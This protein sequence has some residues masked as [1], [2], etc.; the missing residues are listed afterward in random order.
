LASKS[1]VLL[2]NDQEL[3]PL[4]KSRKIAVIG[5][6]ADSRRNMLGTWSVSGDYTKAVTVLEGIQSVVGDKATIVYAK[7]ANLSDDTSFAKKVNVFGLE[8]DMDKKN[9]DAL[10]KEAIQA[11]RQSDVV[12]AVVGEAADMTGEASSMADI[13]LQPSQKKL[14]EALKKTGKPIVMVLYNGRPM[15]LKWE[16]DNM[17]AILDVWFGG[18]EGGRAV[19]DV[20]FGDSNPQGRLTTSFPVQVGQIPVYHAMLN[21]GRPYHGESNSKYK[22]N[23]LDIPNEPLYPF[24]YGLTYSSVSYGEPAVSATIMKGGGSVMVSAQISNTGSTDAVETVQMY[25][26][27]VVGTIARPVKELKGFQQI[28][29]KPGES[30]TV[31]FT[32]DESLLKFYNGN[33]QY[34]AEPGKFEVM[35]G[36]NARDTK[37]V[38]FEYK[39]D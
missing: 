7:G 8:I 20:L 9:P 19:A 34:G 28:N 29:L 24:G 33:L 25:I 23:Y 22:S 31:S 11:A 30:K 39:L 35:I 14:L 21:T 17:N 27:D 5:P 38:S 12:I 15:T 2:K 18:T 10:L 6:L 16:S 32:I 1:F 37:A 26:H 4:Q 13:S 36:P 3:L